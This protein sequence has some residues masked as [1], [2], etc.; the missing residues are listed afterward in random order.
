MPAI[1]IEAMPHVPRRGNLE[2]TLSWDHCSLPGEHQGCI[3]AGE[4]GGVWLGCTCLREQER[5]NRGPYGRRCILGMGRGI[6]LLQST[7]A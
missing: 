1:L 7:S 4:Q 5:G 2:A 6:L 3:Q